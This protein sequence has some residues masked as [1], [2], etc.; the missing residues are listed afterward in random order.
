VDD[1]VAGGALIAALDDVSPEVRAKAAGSLGKLKE[2]GSLDRLLEM[3]LSDPV[4]FVRTRVSQA[5]GSIGHP[6][7][8][9]TLIRVLKDPEWWVRIRAIEALEQI[10]KP[11][12]GAL[13]VALEDD[14]PEVVRRAATALERMGYVHESIETLER[15]GYRADVVKIL[16]LVGK[17]GVTEM[18]FGNIATAKE[19]ARKILVRLA[20]DIGNP[21][22]GNVLRLL[23]DAEKNPSLRSRVVEALGKLAF[24][25]A[26]PEILSCLR[27]PNEWVRRAA[28]VALSAMGPGD[29]VDELLRL[30][31]DPAP[32]TR[33]AVC[34]RSEL[35]EERLWGKS[36]GC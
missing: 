13:L 18:I 8:I 22:A 23:L 11:A 5:L 32:Q 1:P 17:A 2:A 10:G 30:M 14:D 12:S 27:D 29:H 16:H 35:G 25:D 24:R 33:K 34:R 19:P 4:P 28:V 20:G 6:R 36:S 26:I 15:D 9:D 21:A 31:K 3:L 7:V